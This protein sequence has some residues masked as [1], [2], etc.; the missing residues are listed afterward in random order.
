MQENLNTEGLKLGHIA[1]RKDL[2]GQ[3]FGKLTVIEMLYSYRRKKSGQTVTYCRCKCDCGN[4]VLRQAQKLKTSK[5]P[6]CGCAKREIIRDTCGTDVDGQKFGQLTVLETLWDENPVKL[7]CRCDCGS[8]T[9]IAKRDVVSGHTQSCG[10]LHKR[11]TSESNTK[12]F[13]GKKNIHGIEAIQPLHQN[14]RGVWIWEF[15]C[16]CGNVFNGLPARV[17]SDT[18]PTVSCGCQLRSSGEA[19]IEDFLIEHEIPYRTQATYPDCRNI[20]KLRFDFALYDDQ[21]NLIALLEY[22]GRQHYEP[23]EWFGGEVGYENTK[24]R[25]QIKNEYCK[26]NNIALY[27]IPYT[28]TPQEISETISNIIYA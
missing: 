12:D 19:F 9:I 1:R 15:R 13:T 8:E 4:I 7:R 17:F 16:H 5:L 6:S 10:C 2:T 21:I 18:R 3:K 11:R 26:E 23:I 20:N 22:D 14:K 25:D 24:L 27:R 28:Y